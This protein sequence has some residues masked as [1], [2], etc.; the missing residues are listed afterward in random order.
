[1]AQK[2][3][4]QRVEVAKDVLKHLRTMKVA[5]GVYFSNHRNPEIK[6]DIPESGDLQKYLG[7]VTKACNVCALGGMFMSFV[8]LYDDVQFGSDGDDFDCIKRNNHITTSRD[9]ITQKLNNA[10][11][12]DDQL[13][14]IEAAFETEEDDPD[15]Y[16]KETDPQYWFG[17]QFK[18]PKQKLKAIMLNIIQ[19]KGV[20]K[21]EK[22]IKNLKMALVSQK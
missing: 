16:S 1:M 13:D 3:V 5:H 11:F 9:L 18:T 8:R 7:K 20:F 4:D 6:L 2:K 10:G 15:Y 21:P 17:S 19:N 22:G 12:S 14:L